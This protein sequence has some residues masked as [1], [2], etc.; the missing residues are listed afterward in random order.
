ML[1]RWIEETASM[2]VRFFCFY[3]K[4]A[5]MRISLSVCKR[6][7]DLRNM[8]GQSRSP[9]QR[10]KDKVVIVMGATG[11]G[12][13]RLSIDLATR[14]DG[15]IINSDKMQVYRGL[16]VITNKVTDEE[17][18]GV[19]HHLLGI[20]DPDEDFTAED[21][22]YHATIAAD[23]I[24]RRGRLPI[25]AGGSNSYIKALVL[26]DFEFRSKYECC[27]LC[28]NVA[29][30]VLHSFVS[31]RVDQMV[32]AGL[33]AEARE[34]F[35]SRGDYS[36]GIKRSIGVPE[37]DEYFRNESV[38]DDETRAKTLNAAI[39]RV[40][41]NTC[42]LSLRQLENI[43]RLEENL[44][45]RMHRLDAT[46]AILRQGRAE[47]DQAWEEAV[48]VPATMIVGHFISTSTVAPPPMVQT[49]TSSGGKVVSAT[50]Y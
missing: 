27:I 8:V 49:T 40:K 41:S 17:C 24:T 18:R 1:D 20:V 44:E 34:F 16:S 7:E 14:F 22:V 42:T 47:S 5:Y 35:D 29:T 31:K 33:V 4:I 50:M 39:D 11:T 28:V 21:F 32:D 6:I 48:T 45:W 9:G 13:S 23:A 26:D 2:L 36:H 15:E 19:P 10:R 46:E 3:I 25:I 37:M 30:P 12:K 43:S 38:L